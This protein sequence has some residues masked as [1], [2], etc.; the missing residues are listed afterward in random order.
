MNNEKRIPCPYCGEMILQNAYKCRFCGSWLVEGGRES[1]DK[2]MWAD[3]QREKCEELLDNGSWDDCY[4]QVLKV[5]E[6]APSI[7]W[8]QEILTKL[9]KEKTEELLQKIDKAKISKPEKAKELALE[10]L[11]IDSSNSWAKQYLE[12]LSL[13]E[14]KEKKKTYKRDIRNALKGKKY[15]KTIALCNQA[16]S[17]NLGGSWVNDALVEVGESPRAFSNFS[18]LTAAVHFSGFWIVGKVNGDIAVLDVHE[19]QISESNI[20]DFHK[21]KIIALVSSTSFLFG[22]SSDGFVSKWDKR[23]NLVSDFKLNVRPV[24]ADLKNDKLLIGSLEGSVI[25]VKDD[26]PVTIFEEKNGISIVFYGKEKIHLV[27]LYGN[28]LVLDAKNDNFKSRKKKDL[29]YA[30][31]SFSNTSFSTVDGSIY[32]GD[33]NFKKITLRSSVLD[34]LNIGENY[35]A[36]GH[37]GLKVIG[38]NDQDLASR[39]TLMI[40]FNGSDFLCYKGDNALELWSASRWLN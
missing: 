4:S 26:K 29:N 6:K 32:F 19:K 5:L 34:L 20:L 10:I 40:A 8:A 17:E 38:K 24:C 37:F 39:S 36:A 14:K 28:L 1:V 16:V 9:K 30:G 12:D 33:K 25:V 31:L 21:K 27:D 7:Q 15:L 2:A 3:E 23:L 35:L 11:S 13:S 22:V 18:G